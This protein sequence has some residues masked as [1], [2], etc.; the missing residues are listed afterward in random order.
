MLARTD[1]ASILL[2][3]PDARYCSVAIW[4]MRIGL[5][6]AAVVLVGIVSHR[7]AGLSTPT[8]LNLFKLGFAGAAFALL[9]SAGAAIRIWLT[10]Q[11]GAGAAFIGAM[12]SLGVLAWPATYVFMARDLPRINDL[13]TDMS[14]PPPFKAL[15]KRRGPGAN[16]A[17][18]PAAR[19]A[20]LQAQGYPDLRPMFVERS[21]EEVFDLVADAVR[22]EL[23][24]DVVAEVA[25]GAGP[26]Q[27]GFIEAVDRT[28]IL[29]FYDDVAIRVTGDKYRSRIDVRSA[30]R[31]G[32]HDFGRNAARV[33]A[34]L[35][36]IK[37]GLESSVPGMPPHRIVR[38][39]KA[40]PA[41]AAVPKRRKA[42]DRATGDRRS[43]QDR[44]RSDAQHGQEPK[45]RPR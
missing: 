10:G 9:L 15:A 22:S 38:G 34:I 14:E 41:K 5:F 36:V 43:E 17:D 30:S 16:P 42:G 35:R 2:A 13:T 11:P 39:S 31:Y 44:A 28:L 37:T 33:R 18:Y 8:A 26:E 1:S 6:S 32:Q 40:A 19:F 12:A 29:G 24:Y 7:L 20:V 3:Q 4:A 27:P 25:P 23:K 45:A 21:A